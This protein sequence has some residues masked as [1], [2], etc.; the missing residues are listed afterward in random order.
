MVLT[1]PIIQA[2]LR[3]TSSLPSSL[4]HTPSSGCKKSSCVSC[5]VICHC[6]LR[7]C[8]ENLKLLSNVFPDIFFSKMVSVLRTAQSQVLRCPCFFKCY[9][10]VIIIELQRL[11][12]S[13]QIPGLFSQVLSW[14]TALR[15]PDSTNKGSEWDLEPRRVSWVKTMER[16]QCQGKGFGFD[17]PVQGSIRRFRPGL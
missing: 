1:A 12:A 13:E 8:P 17:Y 4:L 16:L 7:P 2:A 9:V 15:Y 3:L 14:G 5:Q 6:L 10:P 11:S